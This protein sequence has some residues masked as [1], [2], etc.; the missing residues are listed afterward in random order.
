MDIKDIENGKV[1][2][3]VVWVTDFRL[4][5]QD[6]F[7]KPIRRVLPT[8]VLIR[9]ND[10]LPNNKRIYYSKSHFVRLNAKG[11]PVKSGI[12][13]LYDNTG[14][15][16]YPGVPLEVYETEEEAALAWNRLVSENEKLIEKAREEVN[17]QFDDLLTKNQR[18]K[19]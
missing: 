4:N 8:K 19:I 6:L 10:E 1:N 18:I 15:R 17:K 12:I 13:S 11:E 16:G 2:G 14:Y 9:S 7:K 5:N 3:K